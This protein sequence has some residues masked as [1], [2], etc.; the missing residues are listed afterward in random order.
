MLA[1]G[2]RGVIGIGRVK[3]PTLAIVCLRELEIRNFQ[4][5][6]YFRI[7]ATATVA[8][9]SFPMRHAPSAKMRIKDRL[10][11]EAIAKAAAGHQ[12]PLG[13]S[14][15]Q[16]RQAPPRLSIFRPCRRP[17]AKGGVG[18]PTRRFRWRKSF[19]TATARN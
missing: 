6:D 12:G 11:A 13:V 8:G 7:V 15:E 9:G 1:P 17:A 3:T 4:P 5:E 2:V 14:I 16:K 18:R 19:M 10:R